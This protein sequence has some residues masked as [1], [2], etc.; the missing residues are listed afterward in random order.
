MAITRPLKWDTASAALKQMTDAELELVAYQLRK[1][2][3]TDL[4]GTYTGACDRSGGATATNG[5]GACYRGDNDSPTASGVTHLAF[6]QDKR[7][8]AVH[9]TK[10]DAYNEATWDNAGDNDDT[11]SA[12]SEATFDASEAGRQAF[13]YE[14]YIGSAPSVPDAATLKAHSYLYWDGSGYSK[15]EGV[16]ANLID[17]IIKLAN[18]E[19]MN[20]DGV[21]LL[22][23][24]TSSPGSD[25][26]DLGFFH[27]NTIMNWSSY[28][29]GLGGADVVATNNLYIRTTDSSY[30]EASAKSASNNIFLRWDDSSSNI[31]QADTSSSFTLI[32]N[33]LMPVW[34]RS[35]N[36]NGVSGDYAFPRYKF[37]TSAPASST[38]ERQMGTLLDTVYTDGTTSH[39]GSDSAE[40]VGGA[41]G[42][43][44]IARYGSGATT[45]NTTHYM[46]A[47][48]ANANAVRT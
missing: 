24:A 48:F 23:L 11:F 25:Y 22:S 21:G 1:A 17:T 15:V 38:F 14:E 45:T 33:V 40:L 4:S 47:Y 34:K 12:P 44:Y 7:K 2:W 26:T 31:K 32:D 39:S 3:A 42:T 46:V 30:D 20:G 27:Q 43:Y 35:S 16:E 8:N 18:Y 5:F 36:F 29:T 6:L 19:M 37:D 13:Y 41:G 9:T 10:T 28:D